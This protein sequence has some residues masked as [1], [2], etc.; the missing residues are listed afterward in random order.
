ME[1]E[2]LDQAAKH[3][4]LGPH[5]FAA[6]DAMEKFMKDFDADQFEPIV[7]KA[8]EDF[9]GK[10]LEDVQNYLLS[11]AESN[12]QGEI[13]RGI[14]A[15]VNAL[16]TGEQW[17]LNRYCLMAKY[18]DGQK[19]RAAVAKEIPEELQIGRLADLEAEVEQLRKDLAWYRQR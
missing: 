17:A 4:E 11:N 6:R 2:Y 15:S 18:G 1:Q 8:S 19:I 5:Y 14:D 9:Y 3:P 10:L 12:L 16:M 13:W 7:K